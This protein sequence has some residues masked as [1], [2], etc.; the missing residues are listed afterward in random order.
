MKKATTIVFFLCFFALLVYNSATYAQAQ[1]PAQKAVT[2]ITSECHAKMGKDKF[3][4]G[5]VATGACFSCHGEAPRHETSPK[6]YKFGKIKD[7]DKRCFACHDQFAARKFIHKP[8]EDRDCS[9][10]HDPHGSPYRFQLLSEKS[11]LCFR[12]HDKNIVKGNFVHGPVAVGGCIA[13][14][15]P[16][17]ADYEKNLKA[18]G[19]KLC[20]KC[21]TE[22]AEAF[23]KAKVMHKPVS[24]KCTK[25][26]SPHASEKKFMLSLD[27]PDLCYNCHKDK[28][29]WVDKATVQH[30]SLITGKTCL[31]CHEVH[32]SNFDK[33]LPLAPLDLCLSCHDKELKTPDGKPIANMKALLM[34][35]SYHHG[36][37]KQQDCSGC[38][39]T[40][41]S[42][43][44]RILKNSYPPTFYMP[45]FSENYNL[46]FSCHEKTIAQNSETTKLTNFRNGATNLH[47]LHVNKP[48]KG[49]TC[50]SCHE[51]HA[52]NSPKHI[53][54]SVPFG[55]WYLPLNYQKTENGGSCLPGCHKMKKYD[56][57]KKEVYE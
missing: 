28:K 54:E 25:C 36:P 3:V 12:C 30:G 7:L 44:F 11:A 16:H 46:C 57:V 24:E 34:E 22:Q 53:R 29:E 49:R 23:M 42:S 15:E 43:N 39:N 17:T 21:H 18:E 2:C 5:P 6:S 37:I 52:S 13:C 47:F 51:T 4:H 50:R 56:R 38:H 9:A 45:F 41:G 31:N 48:D 40:H 27:T 10:C 35:N 14:H 55:V 32:V 33:M 20:Y 19:A 8:V 26:H 1:K